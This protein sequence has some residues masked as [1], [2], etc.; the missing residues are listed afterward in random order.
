ML[1]QVVNFYAKVYKQLISNRFNTSW[2]S[3]FMTRV[4]LIAITDP[5]FGSVK[6]RRLIPS[7]TADR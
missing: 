3:R 6:G 2:M 1:G 4:I 5:T 7:D